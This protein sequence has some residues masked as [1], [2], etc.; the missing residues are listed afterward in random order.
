MPLRLRFRGSLLAVILVLGVLPLR[1]LA[2]G[3]S[4]TESGGRHCA[5]HGEDRECKQHC[6]REQRHTHDSEP[7]ATAAAHKADAPHASA[8]HRASPGE[9]AESAASQ[10]SSGPES[11]AQVGAIQ[12]PSGCVMTSCGNEAPMLLTAQGQLYLAARLVSAP[13]RQAA[14]DSA[15]IALTRFHSSLAVPPPAPPPKS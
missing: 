5:L 9:T 4:V 2:S 15:P 13:H 11:S 6:N 12:P 7:P 8:C 10:A 14:I 1:P 3:L